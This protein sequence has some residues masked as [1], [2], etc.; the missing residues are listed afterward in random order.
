MQIQQL[1]SAEQIQERIKVLGQQ[2]SQDFAGQELLAV[3]ILTG[4]L[5]FAADLIRQI[6][7]VDLQLQCMAASSYHGQTQTSGKVDILFDLKS[8]IA[9]KNVL[10]IED[11]VDSGTTLAKLWPILEARQPRQL[12]LVSLLSK[13]SR[14]IHDVHID[15]LGFEVPNQYVVGYG[16]DHHG[17]LRELPYIGALP[18]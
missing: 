18:S 2:I 4:A 15:Y 8:N 7:G 10:L 14:R 12:R 16:F 17:R 9:R 11:I 3:P 13:P 1:F 5:I 6:K